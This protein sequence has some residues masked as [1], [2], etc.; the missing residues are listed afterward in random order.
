MTSMGS[1]YGNVKNMVD[2]DEASRLVSQLDKAMEIPLFF[3]L[4]EHM[5]PFGEPFKIPLVGGGEV[6]IKPG[7]HEVPHNKGVIN[8]RS[9]SL[10]SVVGEQYS[11]LQHG[12]ALGV[13]INVIQGLGMKAKYKVENDGNVARMEVL[14]PE[15]TIKDD[16][17]QGILLGVRMM[18]SYDKSTSFRGEFFGYRQV[19]SNGMYSA[20]ILGE[21]NISAR[22]VG[23]NFTGL[24]R[25]VL[26]FVQHVLN[27]PQ[28]VEDRIK[29]AIASILEF[30]DKQEI[31]DTVFTVYPNMGAAE[32]IAAEIPLKANRWQVYNAFTRYLSHEDVTHR[33]RD[34]VARVAEKVLLDQKFKPAVLKEHAPMA[35][36]V[37]K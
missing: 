35:K 8:L 18:N 34:N 3:K 32:K 23:E 9:G 13:T 12:D 15:I 21:V 14:F 6:E 27:S 16:S 5:T 28:V 29:E 30:S 1:S 11:V 22:H 33:N 26:Q 4:P 10:A 20:K 25:V 37:A 7:F 36:V 19:C 17:K 24:E 31:Y 2:F